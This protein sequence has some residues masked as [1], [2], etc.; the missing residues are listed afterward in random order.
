MFERLRQDLAAIGKLADLVLDDGF[1]AGHIGFDC[2]GEHISTLRD[3]LKLLSDDLVQNIA[4]LA[5]L[6]QICL[7]RPR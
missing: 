4:V 3:A 1:E 7:Q 5:D 2:L 6:A